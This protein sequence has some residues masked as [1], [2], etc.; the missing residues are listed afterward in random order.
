M[1]KKVLICSNNSYFSRSVEKDLTKNEFIVK[2]TRAKN[3]ELIKMLEDLGPDLTILDAPKAY[4]DGIRELM[5]I[6]EALDTPLMMLST[7]GSRAD[8][9]NAL[10]MASNRPL[11]KPVTFEELL[12]QINFLLQKK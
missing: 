1:S 5:E 4:I 12:R 8:T 11:I 2:S 3:G 9:V 10:S 7:Q 6:R